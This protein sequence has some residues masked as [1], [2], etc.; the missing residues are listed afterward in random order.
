MAGEREEKRIEGYDICWRAEQA[1]LVVQLAQAFYIN[2][3]MYLMMHFGP[4]GCPHAM[5]ER[6][7]PYLFR[8]PSMRS[9]CTCIYACILVPI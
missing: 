1:H 4:Q 2:I 9:I 5:C 8:S 6:N 7:W 3:L